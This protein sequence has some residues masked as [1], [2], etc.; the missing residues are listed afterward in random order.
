MYLYRNPWYNFSGAFPLVGNAN[1]QAERTISYEFGVEH[2]FTNYAVA[3]VTAFYK[4][5][6]DL[7]DTEQIYYTIANYYTRYT[8]ADFARVRGFEIALKLRP[9][10]EFPHFSGSMNYTFSVASGKS[11]TT[12]QNY[13][14]I[15]SGWIIPKKEFPLEWDERHRISLNVAFTVPKGEGFFGNKFLT[16]FGISTLTN[17]GSGMPWTPSSST[18]EQ[19]INQARLPWTLIT[20]MKLSKNFYIGKSKLTIYTNID[21]LFDRVDNIRILTDPAW[22]EA[23]LAEAGLMEDEIISGSG[24]RKEKAKAAKGMWN[25]PFALYPRRHIDVGIEFGF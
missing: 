10:G 13:D 25:D 12:R 11:S 5:V 19:R 16:D 14:Y 1:L 22:Y 17:F 4:D 24:Y 15:W 7:L 9:G 3:D 23:K 18:R 8:N 21:N 2:A 6:T 20:D